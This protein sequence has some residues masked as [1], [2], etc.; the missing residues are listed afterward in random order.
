MN[1]GPAALAD[2]SPTGDADPTV[3]FYLSDGACPCHN[4]E[5]L[6]NLLTIDPI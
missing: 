6:Q 2:S 1:R 4:P 3:S 5:R